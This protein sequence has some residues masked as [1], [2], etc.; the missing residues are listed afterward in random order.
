MLAACGGSP[1]PP[2]RPARQPTAAEVIARMVAAYHGAKTY[3]D[4]GEVSTVFIKG[5]QRRTKR[6]PFTIAYERGGVFRYEFREEG[7]P[8]RAYIVWSDGKRT[9][10]SGIQQKAS[11]RLALAAATGVSG[12]SA[13]ETTG[14]LLQ[15]EPPWYAR[16]QAIVE[17]SD[18]IDGKPCWRLFGQDPSEPSQVT[19]WIDRESY[20]LRRILEQTHFTA[21]EEHSEL[22]AETTTT[23]APVFNAPVDRVALAEP[24]EPREP[25]WI[26]ARVDDG[27]RITQVVAGA[28]GERAGMLLGDRIV[29]VDGVA[30]AN[31]VE[32]ARAVRNKP[33]GATVAV[34]FERAGKPQ[35]VNVVV[36]PRP[37]SIAQHA[38]LGKPAPAFSATALAGLHSS[39][40]ADHKGHVVVVDFWATWCGPCAT[41]IPKLNELHDK[42][43]AAGLRIIGLSSEDQSLIKKFVVDRG[44]KYAIGHD[45]DDRIAK[46]FLCRGLPMFVVIDRAGIVRHVVTDADLDGLDAAVTAALAAP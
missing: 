16:V 9:L 3:A 6:L 2:A 40:L 26:G 27:G 41:S 45:P 28:P 23:F 4:R 20:V 30:V 15:A 24:E 32:F 17:G 14:M 5:G 33:S 44:M 29:S 12:G 42:Y 46:D 7:D 35:T 21:N 34:V 22:D 43:A 18:V 10:T 11:L 8:D 37:A 1:K 31:N 25:M 13:R 36:E 39:T 19:V 38:L